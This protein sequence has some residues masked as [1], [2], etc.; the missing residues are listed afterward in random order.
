VHLMLQ[1]NPDGRKEAET[2]L[3]WR[4][5]TD[6]NYCSDTNDRGADL[7]RNFEFQWGCCGGSSGSE[8]DELYRGPAPASEPEVQAV[9]NYLR[10]QF[11]D[12][13][14]DDLTA[15]APV[16]T[17]GIYLDFHSYGELVL[18]PWGFT[19]DVPPNGTA[20]QTLGRKLAFFNDYSPEQA[21]GLYPTDGTTD[22]FAYGDL[23]LAAYTVEVGTTFFQPCS[24]FENTILP[25]NLA[26]LVYAAKVVRTPYLTPA[27]PDTLDVALSPTQ[28]IV[29]SSMHLTATVDDTR[30]QNSN[31]VE[32]AQFVVAAEYT[33]DAPPWVTTTVPLTHPM[34]ALD[35]AFDSPSEGVAARVDTA[36]LSAGRHILFVRGQDA[37][38]NWGPVS[39]AF[40][41]LAGSLSYLPLVL[42]GD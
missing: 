10:S 24:P 21:I 3:S 37:D 27:G 35:G 16:T 30:Y 18:W 36:G 1:A 33:I 17:A 19:S 38:G 2:G 29:G 39:A 5:N 41:D 12:Q 7:N 20:L 22:D 11:P 8:C 4:K 34:A 13:R 40:F 6:N 28:L 42:R 23:G 26:A 31:G 25:D 9:Q 15:P 14:D 32:L